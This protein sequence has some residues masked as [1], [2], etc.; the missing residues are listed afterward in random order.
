MGDISNHFNRGEFSCACGCGFN[1][2]DVKLIELLEH[3]RTFFNAPLIVT[4]GCRCHEYNALIGGARS[5]QHT[6]GMAADIRISGVTPTAIA[7]EAGVFLGNTGGIGT[8]E[9]WVHV[10]VRSNGP[11]RWV[12]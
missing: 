3:L 1:T 8:Y 9:S 7:A 4:S 2:V 11:A 6:R 10:D 5:S 12:G